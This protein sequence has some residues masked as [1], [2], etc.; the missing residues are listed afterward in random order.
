M[1]IFLILIGV[2]IIFWLL[3]RGF[4][5][6]SLRINKL[7]YDDAKYLVM[8]TAKV[9]KSD[10]A[11]SK[12]EANYISLLLDDICL[13]LG[14]RDVRGKLKDIYL[15]YKDTQISAYAIAKE[16]RQRLGFSQN[17]WINRVV[18]FMNLAYIDGEFNSDEREILREICDGFTINK[19]IVEELF[20]HF[21]A[22]F[23]N[24]SKEH[25]IDPYEIL[26]V[27]KD[28]S[29]EE[30]KASHRRLSRQYHP[31]FM[32]DKSDDIISQAT[33]KMQQINEA[34]EILKNK[35]NK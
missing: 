5:N 28:A 10:G 15:Y 24:L 23:K 11:V 29:F 16:Y 22:E 14:N 9:A 18:F 30:I 3:G 31:D 33:K 21:E 25:S 27:S 6:S 19:S 32:M 12:D 26:E 17:I 1:H 8:L 4:T 20:S 7:Q 2:I 13:K 34:Y 35:F